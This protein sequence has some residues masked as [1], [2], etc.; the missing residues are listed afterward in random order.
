VSSSCPIPD[1]ILPHSAVKEQKKKQ[2][3]NNRNS[4]R[5]KNE[6]KSKELNQSRAVAYQFSQSAE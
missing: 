4:G 2:K 1:R 5:R 6:R 3:E